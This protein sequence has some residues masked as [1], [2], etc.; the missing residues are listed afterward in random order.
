MSLLPFTI[1]G[2]VQHGKHLGSKLGF[3]TANLDYQK[4]EL[5]WPENGVYAGY[6]TIDGDPRRYPCMLNQGHHPT[7][8]EG[9]PTV[10]VHL[11]DYSGK[12]L[13]GRFLTVEY[14]LFLRP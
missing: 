12:P 6:A 5:N 2:P 7:A 1:S 11:L 3:P 13:Y 8:P 4:Q 9:T 14:R 10:E